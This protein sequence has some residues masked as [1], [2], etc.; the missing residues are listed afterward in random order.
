MFCEDCGAKLKSNSKFC[1]NCGKEIKSIK[2]EK[3]I[4]SSEKNNKTKKIVI[5]S[6]IAFIIVVTLIVTSNLCSA[7]N[8]AEVY[9]KAKNSNDYATMYK[10]LEIEKTEFTT[11]ELYIKALKNDNEPVII[12]DYNVSELKTSE[13]EKI[14]TITYTL[15]GHNDYVSYKLKKQPNNKLLL[16]GN[17]KIDASNDDIIKK[18]FKIKVIKGSNVSLEGINV[19]QKYIDNELSNDNYDV[20]KIPAIFKGK[21]NIKITLPFGFSIED[22]ISTYSDYTQLQ[23]LNL[24]SIPEETK[25]KLSNMAKKD[26][27]KLYESAN[28][29]KEYSEITNELDFVDPSSFSYYYDGLKSIFSN[30]NIETISFVDN[31]ISS[32]YFDSGKITMYISFKINY[33]VKEEIIDDEGISKDE[34][35]EKTVSDEIYFDF[36]YDN[37][38][39]ILAIGSLCYEF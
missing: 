38:F 3:K 22:N 30:K 18:D 32:I 16:F 17:W 21:Y 2:A 27:Q 35:K 13:E 34:Y 26:I 37:T 9:F 28:K 20:Y 31:G 4:V 5:I 14:I 10:H 6:I 39:K 12:S 24:E 23:Y 33:L 7:Q 15:N 8:I 29:Q 1:E 19:D 11:K 25:N 36:A